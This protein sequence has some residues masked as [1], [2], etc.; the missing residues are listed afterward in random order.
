M[1]RHSTFRVSLRSRFL[2]QRH[3]ILNRWHY[4]VK[5]DLKKK[6]EKFANRLD[7]LRE[8]CNNL[9]SQRKGENK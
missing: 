2:R 5:P 3:F 1:G 9:L 8:V 7:N 4:F 6:L